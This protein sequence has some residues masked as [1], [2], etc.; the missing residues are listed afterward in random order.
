MVSSDGKK[1]YVVGSCD[2]EDVDGEFDMVRL[3]A[4]PATI[5]RRWSVIPLL[6]CRFSC[7]VAAVSYL[8]IKH[9]YL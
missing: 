6:S 3:L 2:R 5:G 4:K 9:D 8:I 7:L 1:Q